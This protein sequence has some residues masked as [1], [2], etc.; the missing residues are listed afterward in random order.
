MLITSPCFLPLST[1]CV[2]F[3]PDGLLMWDGPDP[4][5]LTQGR[6]Y[7]AGNTSPLAH[8]PRENRHST[9][10]K[11]AGRPARH[12]GLSKPQNSFYQ[13]KN[14]KEK[15]G[16]CKTVNSRLLFIYIPQDSQSLRRRDSARRSAPLRER[17]LAVR[18][19][20]HVF[21]SPPTRVSV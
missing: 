14:K 20:V 16:T 7:Q 17:T 11:N 12:Q 3:P 4:N 6:P 10:P 21:P 1:E 13:K 9:I 18:A 19:S 5:I 15:C 2:P 8:P